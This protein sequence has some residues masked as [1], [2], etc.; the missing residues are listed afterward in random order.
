M[1]VSVFAAE[2]EPEIEVPEVAVLESYLTNYDR[3][4]WGSIKIIQ[5]LT[6]SDGTIVYNTARVT[7][8]GTIKGR[9]ILSAD[10]GKTKEELKG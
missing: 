3:T 10:I 9:V 1:I 8:R 5:A 2:S 4:F 7:R 6:F